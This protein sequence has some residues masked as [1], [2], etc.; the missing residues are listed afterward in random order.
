M[1]SRAKTPTPAPTPTPVP[2]IT[3]RA[4]I[5]RIGTFASVS[6]PA[7]V[8]RDFAP[9]GA[10]RRIT[11]TGSLN[12]SPFHGTLLPTAQGGHVFFLNAATRRESGVAVGDRVTFVLSPCPADT[13]LLSADVAAALDAEPGARAAFD[14]LAVSHRKQLLRFVTSASS[15]AARARAIARTVDH[16]LGRPDAPPSPSPSRARTRPVCPLC[17]RR[18]AA[19]GTE[20]P[21][22]PPDLSASFAKTPVA[23]TGLFAR[24]TSIVEECGLVATVAFPVGAGFV[25]ERRFLTVTP[26][27]A[28]LEL[29]FYLARRAQHARVSRIDTLAPDFHIHRVRVATADDLD[30]WLRERVDE[31]YA[32]GCRGEPDRGFG[33]RPEV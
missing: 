22:T 30:D 24:L 25:A 9:W 8:T 31:A 15:P 14:A 28:W 3:F 26:R 12:A 33:E 10:A 11:V 20:H 17:G 7:R 2:T 1:K 27:K 5:G 4:D 21:C 23:L 6:V 13:V 18:D 16:C 19:D 32:F 29:G